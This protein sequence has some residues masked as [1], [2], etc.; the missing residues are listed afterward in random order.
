[1]SLEYVFI[2]Q[3]VRPRRSGRRAHQLD[4]R[5]DGRQLRR[6]AVR[7][8]HRNFQA[9]ARFRRREV[10]AS[11]ETA[12]ILRFA[13]KVAEKMGDNYVSAEHLVL[14]SFND[15]TPAVKNLLQSHGSAKQR[16]PGSELR[17]LRATIGSAPKNARLKAVSNESLRNVKFSALEHMSTK[18][19]I[20]IYG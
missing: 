10:C 11:P 12:K 13:D 6:T 5:Q 8:R 2:L 16:F 18:C 1:M 15:G 14:G 19:Y 7:A 3:I 4:P 9:A 20:N 17:L